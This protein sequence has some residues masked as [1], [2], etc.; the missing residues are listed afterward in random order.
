MEKWGDNS[1]QNPP[2]PN[3]ISPWSPKRLGLALRGY[4]LSVQNIKNTFLIL[5]CTLF[6]PQNSLNVSG[7]GLYK[8]SKAF[9]RDASH[10]WLG[11]LL[12]VDHCWY[13]RETVECGKTQQ[14][15]S[16]WHKLVR[17]APTT[18]PRSK[19]LKYFVIPFHPLNG[20]HTQSISQLSQYLNIL[21]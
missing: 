11:V 1:W 12:V 4:I 7:H 21:L 3:Q 14:R 6:C 15:C 18:I 16:S 8:V 10:S 17:L 2:P 20:T 19:A 13:T 9:H 5:S